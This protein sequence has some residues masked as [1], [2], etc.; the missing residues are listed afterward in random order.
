M[1]G[2]DNINDNSDDN[3]M[4]II[5]NGDEKDHEKDDFDADE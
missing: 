1:N 4:T 5:I 3:M 2:D